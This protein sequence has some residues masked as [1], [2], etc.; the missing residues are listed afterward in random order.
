MRGRTFRCIQSVQTRKPR[1]RYVFITFEGIDGSGK[2]TTLNH[3]AAALRERGHKVW[4]T[5]EETE[6]F[7]GDAIRTSIA[8][9]LDPLCTTYLFLADRAEHA[10]EIE[11]HLA[12]GDI[13]L[14][15]RFKHSTYAYQSV[16]LEGRVPNVTSFLDQLHAP[17]PLEPDHVVLFDVDPK[18]SV[19]RAE[20]RGA[21]TPYEKAVFLE[22]VRAAYLAQ[23]DDRFTVLDANAPLEELTSA[24][25]SAV[26]SFLAF[27]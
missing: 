8:N 17:I 13:V 10:A 25:V 9:R 21:T 2:S 24:G 18:V 19:A 6:T 22:K 23:K 5:R 3:V 27:P 1:C 15:D 16:T 4:T 7:I 14:C 12:A 11:A 26:L 20:S